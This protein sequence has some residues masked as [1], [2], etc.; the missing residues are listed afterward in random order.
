MAKQIQDSISDI[1]SFELRRGAKSIN[2][3]D[4]AEKWV[5]YQS[6]QTASTVDSILEQ[7]TPNTSPMIAE[8]LSVH[9]LF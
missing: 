3:P 5:K 8:V 7:I 4:S 2:I 9:I 1:S 6:E